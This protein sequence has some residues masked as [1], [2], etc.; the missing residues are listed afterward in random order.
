MKAYLFT[1]GTVFG[2]L[3]AVHIWRMAVE[4]SSRNP[5]L[6][7]HHTAVDR[8][9]RMGVRVVQGF[10]PYSLRMRTISG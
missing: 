6:I 10:A 2:L 7:A 3:T 4:P 1:T 8:V 5:W 9:L